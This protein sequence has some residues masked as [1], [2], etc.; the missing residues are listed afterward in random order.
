ME[1]VEGKTLWTLALE[2]IANAGK[3][4]LGSL[5]MT[6]EKDPIKRFYEERAGYEI[7]FDNDTEAELQII[8]H[9]RAIAER[10]SPD[11]GLRVRGPDGRFVSPTLKSTSTRI[12]RSSRYST[13]TRFLHITAVLRPFLLKMHENGIYHRDLNVRNLMIRKERKGLR[14]RLRQGREGRAP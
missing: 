13:K 8:E 6:N 10:G 1:C 11:P 14:H 3:L 4:A 9:Y 5:G 2:T 12:W 7:Q